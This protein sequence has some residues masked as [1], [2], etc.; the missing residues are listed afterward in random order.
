MK[1]TIIIVEAL[2]QTNLFGLLNQDY[3]ITDFPAVNNILRPAL[4]AQQPFKGFI[5]D[6]SRVQGKWFIHRI[7]DLE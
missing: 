2:M 5:G 6:Y 3:N 1:V 7:D 4:A